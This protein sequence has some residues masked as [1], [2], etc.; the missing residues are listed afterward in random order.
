MSGLSSYL[1]DRLIDNL[2]LGY[3][4]GTYSSL[5]VSLHS[6]DPIDVGSYELSGNGYNRVSVPCISDYWRKLNNTVSNNVIIT[7]P[8]A[9]S[10]WGTVSHFGIWDSPSGGNMLFSGQ[11]SNPRT[12]HQDDLMSFPVSFLT[13]TFD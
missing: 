4:I 13:V 1:Q 2:F 9:S 3:T 12:I 5:Y 11:L 10:S 7:F 8:T 6:A